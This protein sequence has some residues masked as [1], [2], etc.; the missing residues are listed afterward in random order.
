MT[1]GP[2]PPRGQQARRAR[3][4]WRQS[5]WDGLS[6]LRR[7]PPAQPVRASS[8]ACATQA[9]DACRGG[10]RSRGGKRWSRGGAGGRRG[11]SS[12][13]SGWC[14]RVGRGLLL[15]ARAGAGADGVPFDGPGVQPPGGGG[16]LARGRGYGPLWAT[17]G[18]GA[19]WSCGQPLPRQRGAEFLGRRA[20]AGNSISSSAGG[21]TQSG[22]AADA[23]SLRSCLATA[24]GAAHRQR[25]SLY[26][27]HKRAFNQL[28]MTNRTLR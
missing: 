5:P 3:A 24:A 25:S 23:N 14:M 26:T 11:C 1:E 28:F 8:S 17:L 4:A 12:A 21:L 16:T 10:W 6:A 19:V 7:R 18:W 9:D 13:S 2:L 15:Q 20:G 22:T 27:S